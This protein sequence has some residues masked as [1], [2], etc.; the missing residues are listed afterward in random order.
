MAQ[1]EE[2]KMLFN[3]TYGQYFQRVL[4]KVAE[5]KTTCVIR[6]GGVH[7]VEVKP[8]TTFDYLNGYLDALLGRLH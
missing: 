3:E 1:L 7:Y 2:V 4:K 6:I 8:E 5:E